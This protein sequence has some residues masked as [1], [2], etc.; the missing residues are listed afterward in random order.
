VALAVDETPGEAADAAPAGVVWCEEEVG[1]PRAS[2]VA[3]L[4][5][6]GANELVYPFRDLGPAL[7]AP[8]AVD[9]WCRGIAT[10]MALACLRISELLRA[11]WADSLLDS[12][13]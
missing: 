12:C 6:G 11:W 5:A 1:R 2:G 13:W 9:P 3:D 7:A 8:A 10:L 4:A